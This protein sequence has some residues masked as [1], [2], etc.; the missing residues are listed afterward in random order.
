MKTIVLA[1][2]V[3]AVALVAPSSAHA[4]PACPNLE[5]IAH[6]GYHRGSP[7]PPDENTLPAFSA[8]AARGYNIETDVWPDADGKLW[9]FHDHNVYRMTGVQ[10][11]ITQM[12]S[13]EV[14]QLRTLNTGAPIPSL[15]DAAALFA[16]LAASDPA[17]RFYIETKVKS[18]TAQVSQII[19]DYGI[20]PQT[21]ITA[22]TTYTHDTQ[23]DLNLLL[24]SFATVP[25]P[26]SL[27]AGGIDVV[28][29]QPKEMTPSTMTAYHDNGLEV[30]DWRS[31][32]ATEWQTVIAAGADGILTDFPDALKAYCNSGTAPPFIS[33]FTPT[34]GTAGGTVVTISGSNFT[35]ATSVEFGTVPA[36][37]TVDSDSQISAT[38]PQ[39]APASATLQVD[40]PNGSAVSSGSFRV[41]PVVSA[42]TPTTG[43]PGST[44]VT[45]SGSTFTGATSVEFGTVPASFTVD[46]DSQIS[47]TVPDAAAASAKIRVVTAGGSGLSSQ[48][49]KIPPVIT[50]FTPT[51][52]SVG[53]TQVTITGS[54]FTGATSVKFGLVSATFTVDSPT[55]ISTTVPSTAPASARIRVTTPGGS[56][57]SSQTFSAS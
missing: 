28:S 8:A 53:I 19:H 23:P 48:I 31:N 46:S 44:V 30:Q 36:G 5:I 55:Q 17:M 41:P 10:G 11:L 45:I 24:K 52:G 34:T 14:S 43:S 37:F 21:Y 49:F 20:V 13:D 27:T 16:N 57:Q 54:N 2:S 7:A 47:A 33:S 6:R 35:G 39:T 32:T 29:F 56:V 22:N 25:D 9:V 15:T 38:V 40:T 12:T 42:F 26:A 1:V 3:V 4:T 51:S 18:T 50:D